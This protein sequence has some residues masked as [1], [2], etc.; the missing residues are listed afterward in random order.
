LKRVYERM[1]D[2][3]RTIQRLDMQP[4]AKGAGESTELDVDVND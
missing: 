2:V 3:M 1:I 4:R